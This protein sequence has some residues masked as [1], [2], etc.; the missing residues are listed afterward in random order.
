MATKQKFLSDRVGPTEFDQFLACRA[1]VAIALGV[2]QISE[3][4]LSGWTRFG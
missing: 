4:E 3:T 2:R 1:G